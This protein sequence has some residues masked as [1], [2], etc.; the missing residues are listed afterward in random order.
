MIKIFGGRLLLNAQEAFDFTNGSLQHDHGRRRGI[1]DTI[2]ELDPELKEL[3]ASNKSLQKSWDMSRDYAD[4]LD[5]IITRYKEQFRAAMLLRYQLQDALKYLLGRVDPLSYIEY[6]KLVVDSPLNDGP[7]PQFIPQY[8][9]TEP[10]L[11][12]ETLDDYYELEN[13]PQDKGGF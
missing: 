3:E 7:P 9:D 5:K 11:Y 13:Y 1:L 6:Y 12:A 4:G 8:D 10:E 2:A